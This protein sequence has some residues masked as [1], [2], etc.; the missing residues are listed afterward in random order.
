MRIKRRLVQEEKM[1]NIL[2]ADD[3]NLN[4]TLIIDI[5]KENL[6]SARYYEAHDGAEALDLL[7]QK[8]IDLVILDLMM[9]C[10]DGYQVLEEMKK[11]KDSKDIPVI[12]SSS[13]SD[14][15]SIARTLSMG[16][17]DYFLKPLSMENMKVILP[18]KVKN[19]LKSHYQTSELKNVNKS[20]KKELKIAG[21]FQKTL[22]S[23]F[24]N[25]YYD[26]LHIHLN[27]SP[28]RSL[29]GDLFEIVTIND[30]KWIIMADTKANGAAAAVMSF[31]L[32]DLFVDSVKKNSSPAAVVTEINKSFHNSFKDFNDMYISALVCRIKDETLSFSNAGNPHPALFK[33]FA[34]TSERLECNGHFIGFDEESIYKEHTRAFRKNDC[35]LIHT[36]GLYKGSA[37]PEG[38]DMDT[39]LDIF[40]QLYK[41]GN[42]PIS[43]VESVY[44]E[45]LGMN[46]KKHED[47]ITIA[48]IKQI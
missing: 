46:N 15:D 9:P 44:K 4:R 42:D 45:Y 3:S 34:D 28:S 30:S 8:E 26:D 24:Q 40:K 22:M 14:I 21:A 38:D 23:K 6:E 25:R 11:N 10:M 20:I 35:L 33:S 29:S 5:L 1:Y 43:L 19:S 27:Y 16:A 31:V 12:V 7:S 47:D 32:R 41:N 36:D 2:V 13:V 39:K 37:I 17:S 48:A 18:M